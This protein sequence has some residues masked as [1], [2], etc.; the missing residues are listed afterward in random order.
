MNGFTQMLVSAFGFTAILTFYIVACAKNTV[1]DPEDPNQ[2][3]PQPNFTVLWSVAFMVISMMMGFVSFKMDGYN[4]TKDWLNFFIGGLFSTTFT[5]PAALFFWESLS[6][7]SLSLCIAGNV[8]LV[9]GGVVAMK[10]ATS[11]GY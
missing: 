9:L 4:M 10:M 5:L 8:M 3:L 7:M 6:L 1:K 2:R 11:G